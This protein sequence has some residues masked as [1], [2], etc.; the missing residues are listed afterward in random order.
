MERRLDPIEL[1]NSIGE[2]LLLNAMTIATKGQDGEPH[3]AAVYFVSDDQ[4]N[5]YFFSDAA[6]QHSLDIKYDPRAAVA[7]NGEDGG[8]HE[9][10]GLQM[11]GVIKAVQSKSK[12]LGGWELYQAKFPFVADLQK[13]V[14]QNQMYVFTPFWIRLVDNRQGFGYKQEWRRDPQEGDNPNWMLISG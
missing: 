14:L 9:I 3:A 12:S 8:W 5:L 11:R 6:S 4:I 7:V 2:L 1:K 13:I 10:Y